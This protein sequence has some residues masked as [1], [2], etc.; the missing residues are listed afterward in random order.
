M[1]YVRSETEW[2]NANLT[3]E[4]YVEVK[5]AAR[6]GNVEAMFDLGILYED[7]AKNV[8]KSHFAEAIRY[9]K[10]AAELDH[11]GAA[12]RLGDIYHY[13][14]LGIEQNLSR[15]WD[16]YDIAVKAGDSLGR[17]GRRDVEFAIVAAAEDAVVDAEV[18][19]MVADADSIRKD[20]LADLHDEARYGDPEANYYL[21]SLY[22]SGT[23]DLK[24]DEIEAAYYYRQAAAKG[25]AKANFSLGDIYE[26]GVLGDDKLGKAAYRYKLA[27]EGGVEEAKQALARVRA[28]IG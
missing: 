23:A 24:Q 3:I 10:K 2:P 22:A 11:V 20:K 5:E 8:V 15:A 7:G 12:V 21:G 28:I 27:V 4:R 1:T 18:A 26:S 19:Q 14:G 13:G 25:H 16:Y 9:Y 6:L 17:A